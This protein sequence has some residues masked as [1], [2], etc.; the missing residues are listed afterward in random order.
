MKD[1]QVPL[2]RAIVTA[3]KADAD[4]SALISGRI[5]DKVPQ[6]ATFPYS[7]FGPMTTIG[8][9]GSCG[10]PSEV[11][12]QIDSWSRAVGSVE[13]KTIGAAW[14]ALLTRPGALSVEGFRGGVL[15]EPVLT[16]QRG[17]DQVTSQSIL[18][19]RFGLT[20]VA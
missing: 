3:A 5:F 15:G 1:A 20:A 16:G 14:L 17:L 11:Q 18:R 10:T 4:L 19:L 8:G 12:V 9:G 2:Q 13:A 7:S 6:D